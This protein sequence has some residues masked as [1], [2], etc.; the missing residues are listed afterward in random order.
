MRPDRTTDDCTMVEKDLAQAVPNNV[1]PESE[2]LDPDT[3]NMVI[4]QTTAELGIFSVNF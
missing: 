3:Y 1:F 4:V 2:T